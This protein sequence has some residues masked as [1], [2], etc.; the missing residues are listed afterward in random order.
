MWITFLAQIYTICIEAPWVK[1][2]ESHLVGTQS[3][4]GLPSYEGDGS[5]FA[6]QPNT[7]L[8]DG[9]L[10][11]TNQSGLLYFTLFLNVAILPRD[12]NPHSP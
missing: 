3:Y 10:D 11:T 12:L 5:T 9:N 6:I 8:L 7:R 2:V 1:G 4:P